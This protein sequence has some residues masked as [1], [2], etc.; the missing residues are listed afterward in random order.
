[1]PA[2]AQLIEKTR[3]SRLEGAPQQQ[4]NRLPTAGS[5]C[6]ARGCDSFPPRLW[7]PMLSPLQA[8]ASEV[9]RRAPR[10]TG[11]LVG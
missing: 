8:W 4:S 7:R 9:G 1:M 5:T 3:H 11:G 6:H 10:N 2:V